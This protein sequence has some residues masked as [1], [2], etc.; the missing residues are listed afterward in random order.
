MANDMSL[1]PHKLI[2]PFIADNWENAQMVPLSKLKTTRW[3]E[4]LP[5]DSLLKPFARFMD[6]LYK[7]EGPG[8][9]FTIKFKGKVLGI[10]DVIGPNSGIIDVVVDG[11][12]SYELLRFDGWGNNYRKNAI[13]LKD[14]KEGDHEVTFTVSNKPVDKEAILAK[15]KIPFT[16]PDQYKEQSWFVN[17]I[18]LAGELK[19]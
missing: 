17:N 8:A 18:L 12:P 4:L 13:F 11:Q 6:Y 16:N 2:S 10:Y 19:K 3:K 15:R 1:K 7:A 9:S 5:G 14:L